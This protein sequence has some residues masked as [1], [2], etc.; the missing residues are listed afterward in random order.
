MTRTAVAVY[1]AGSMVSLVEAEPRTA[2][3]AA[4]AD[5]RSRAH[6]AGRSGPCG[7]ERTTRGPHYRAGDFRAVPVRAEARYARA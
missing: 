4:V 7:W 6:A 1:D 2:W 3:R 5:A